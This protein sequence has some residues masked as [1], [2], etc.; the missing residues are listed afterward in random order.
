MIVTLQPK[1]ELNKLYGTATCMYTLRRMDIVDSDED[2]N[3]LHKT[4][5]RKIK[6]ATM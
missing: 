6:Q 4:D 3:K 1:V 2:R 5:H